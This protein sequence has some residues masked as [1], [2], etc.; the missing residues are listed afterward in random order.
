MN[1]SDRPRVVITG[2]G[3]ATPLGMGVETFWERCLQG[4]SGIA[5]IE[6]FDA[7][8]FPCKIGGEVRHF[9]PTDYMDRKTARR[10]ARFSQLAVAATVEALADSGIDIDYEDRSR[11][12]VI[13][14]NGNGGLPDLEAA[15]ALLSEKGAMRLDPFFIPRI[16]PNM[17]AANVA[18][19]FGLLGY[20]TTAVTACA[21]GTQAIGE[22]LEVIRRGAADV[23]VAGG[24]EAGFSALGLGGFSV[25]RALT[26]R[27]DEPT[28]ASR[29]F[30]A[31]RDGF[32]PG[33]GAA[34]LIL[35]S[36]THARARGAHIRAEVA[37]F[38]C[39]GDAFHLVMPDE[40]GAGPIRA[41]RWALADAGIEPEEVDYVN[42]HGTST[43]LNDASE[44]L[45]IKTAL[46]EAAHNVAISSTK[47][48]IGH[49]FGAAGA[50][51]SVAAVKTLESGRIHPTINL[52]TP[53]PAC[54][55]DYVP[56]TA[57]TADVRVVLKNSFG[58]GGQNACLVFRRWDE[59]S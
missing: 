59:G 21:A 55:L 36:E 53:D 43:P 34:I 5:V 20:S 1:N 4:Q 24:T 44:T 16:L 14:G 11:I 27:S 17:A 48:M 52:E 32:V 25:M 15:V 49:G 35:E 18:I 46:G 13:M 12:G 42:A 45:A 29:P 10:M 2:M 8:E 54:D 58:F 57:R 47:S 19:Q 56:L 28:K 40:T 9:V 26:T 22:A 6:S 23:V 41:I 33:E 30:D 39:S 50:I 31:D 51:E 7:S 38:G 3:A 37:G